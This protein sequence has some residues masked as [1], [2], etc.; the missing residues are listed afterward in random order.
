MKFQFPQKP[1]IG[2]L[3]LRLYL[4]SSLFLLIRFKMGLNVELSV[5]N[6]IDVIIS[7]VMMIS[8]VLGSLTRVTSLF[9]FAWVQLLLLIVPGEIGLYALVAHEFGQ[10]IFFIPFFTGP[11][12]YALDSIL[13]KST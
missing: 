11:G 5:I 4:A 13:R 8:S 1:D 9:M 10:L 2:L 7:I 3:L 6:W 12:K